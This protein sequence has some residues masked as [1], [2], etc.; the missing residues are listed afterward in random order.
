VQSSWVIAGK[1]LDVPAGVSSLQIILGVTTYNWTYNPDGTWALTLT[2]PSAGT[3]A[4]S[5]RAT[6]S[7]GN[8]TQRNVTIT[9]KTDADANGLPDD[10]QSSNGLILGGVNSTRT[11]DFDSDGRSNL[12][13]YAFN[14]P[15]N[16]GAVSLYPN[17]THEVKSADGKTYLIYRY[18]RRRGAVDLTYGLQFSTDLVSW[19][20]SSLQTEPAA[21]PSL[22]GDNIT[23]RVTTR[24]LPEVSLMPGQKVFVR[25][26]VTSVVP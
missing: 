24:I 17:A 22:N 1:V 15:A 20:G 12:L 6:D 18:D 9:R 14:T 25:L 7:L 13:E 26:V 4:I 2:I 16:R 10:W 19:S 8:I 11:T 21:P 3:Y 23:E 5:F